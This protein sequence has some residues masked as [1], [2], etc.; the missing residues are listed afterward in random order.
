MISIV[1]SDF[2]MAT[3]PEKSSSSMGAKI[4]P[5]ST[6]GGGGGGGGYGVYYFMRYM[7]TL[8]NHILPPWE[9][10][11]AHLLIFTWKMFILTDLTESISSRV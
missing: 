9:K 2:R 1:R 3:G 10:Y 11:N 8:G 4:S 7:A 5:Y 6:L